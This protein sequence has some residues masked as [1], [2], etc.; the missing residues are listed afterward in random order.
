MKIAIVA[1]SP[2]PFTIG[3]AEKLFLGLQEHINLYTN[4][5]CELIKIPTKEDTF[6]DI[7]DSY[8]KFYQLDLSHFD[9]IISGKYPAWMVHHH[10]HYLYMLHPLRGL[11]D[12]YDFKRFGYD[13]SHPKLEYILNYIQTPKASIKKLFKLLYQL[14][15]D[16]SIPQDL[17]SFPNVFIRKLIHF[18][19]EKALQDIKSFS[20][21]S[22]T[23]ASRKEY[24]LPDTKVKVIY[25]PSILKDFKDTSADYFFTA[26]RLDAPKRVDLIIKAY[27]KADV[28]M[29]LK[30]AGIGDEYPYL[31]KLAQNDKHIEFLGFVSDKQLEQLYAKAYAVIFIPKEEDY[32]LVTIEAMK[33]KKPVITCSDSGG[34]LEFVEDNKTGLIAKPDEESLSQAIKRLSQ[35]R[36][37]AKELGEKAYQKTLPITWQNTINTLI[38]PLPSLTV[39]TTYPIYPPRGGGQNRV[40]YLYRELARYFNITVISLVHSSLTFTK[41]ELSPNLYE[42]QVPKTRLHEEEEEKLREQI[43]IAV[44]DIALLVLY[45]KTPEYI[46]QIK[47]HSKVSSYV[48]TT[49]PYTYPILKKYIKTPIIYESQNVEYLLKKDILKP[50]PLVKK[51]LKLLFETEKECYLKSCITTTCS[52]DDTNNFIKLYGKRVG[53]IPFIPN[54]VDL[55]SVTYFSK[56]RKLKQ[57]RRYKLS[58]KTIA[59]FMGS[60]H[61]PNVDAVKEI[62]KLAKKTP[63]ILYYIIGGVNS[64]FQDISKP[65]N[66][67]F[68]GLIDEKEKNHYLSIADIALNPML[69][70]S[71]TNLKMLDY[72]ASG[73]PTIT[74]PIGARGLGLTPSM[75]VKTPIENFSKYLDNLYYYVDTKEAKR[76]VK[77]RYDWRTIA[78]TFKDYISCFMLQYP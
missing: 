36:T 40:F 56:K 29:P 61:A 23:V 18:F 60:A 68:T 70:G 47:L 30:I 11:Y 39:V 14:K 49:S 51:L 57:K 44:T 45:E 13:L 64:A 6:W 71:G 66:V 54:G 7:I 46:K 24:F 19:D 2:I 75:A 77:N 15:E 53:E 67:T 58:D 22:K 31:K 48:I 3:G 41:K 26:S 38:S 4:H 65:K 28:S 1:P 27:I 21:I 34:V 50:S 12:C 16:D 5:Q 33:C 76:F 43:G 35:D 37:L 63:H 52:K 10:N 55:N 62:I 32:G 20:A 74:T 69:T 78:K 25:P 9:M 73:T 42:V 8:Y 17:L 59:I 72:L